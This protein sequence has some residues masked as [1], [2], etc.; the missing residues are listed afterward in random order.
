MKHVGEMLLGLE[1]GVRGNL[2]Q[3]KRVLAQHR[4]RKLHSFEGH[5]QMGRATCRCFENAC[6]VRGTH[7]HQRCELLD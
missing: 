3:G 2:N 1:T 6:E 4:P 7:V 5:V